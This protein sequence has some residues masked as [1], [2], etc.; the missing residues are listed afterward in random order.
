MMFF[1]K[2]IGIKT[3]KFNEPLLVTPLGIAM[4]CNRG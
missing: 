1:E 2:E 4:N 3:I